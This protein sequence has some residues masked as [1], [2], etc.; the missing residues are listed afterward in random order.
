MHNVSNMQSEVNCRNVYETKQ[1][2]VTSVG[3][4]YRYINV[5]VYI[6]TRLF[7]ASQA[8]VTEYTLQFVINNC[9]EHKADLTGRDQAVVTCRLL[10]KCTTIYRPSFRT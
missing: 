7:E 3:S 2:T 1:K 5:C 9:H 4:V 8:G 10:C 6:M